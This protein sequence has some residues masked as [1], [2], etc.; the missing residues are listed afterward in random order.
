MTSPAH[1]G[2]DLPPGTRVV[3]HGSQ[4]R[5]RGP[6]QIGGG[7]LWPSDRGRYTVILDTGHVLINVRPASVTEHAHTATH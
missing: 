6:G 2:G 4:Y 5:H 7:W 3:Y 1:P